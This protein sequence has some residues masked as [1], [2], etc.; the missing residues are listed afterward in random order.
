[1][2]YLAVVIL[3]VLSNCCISE[4]YKIQPRIVGGQEAQRDLFPFYSFLEIYVPKQ[5]ITKGC[6]ATI[7]SSDWLLTAAHCLKHSDGLIAHFGVSNLND[8]YKDG[9]EAIEV[10]GNNFY[11]HGAYFKPMIWN[12]IGKFL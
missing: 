4:A 2:N 1:M 5:R 9:H 6:G 7:I 10:P 12:D 8:F 3:I 11:I